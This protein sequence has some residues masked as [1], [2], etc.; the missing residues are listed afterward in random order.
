LVLNGNPLTSVRWESSADENEENSLIQNVVDVLGG[1]DGM[2]MEWRENCLDFPE[3]K[4]ENLRKGFP[5]E[6]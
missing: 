1:K 2:G 4:Y 3:S 5:G 6:A